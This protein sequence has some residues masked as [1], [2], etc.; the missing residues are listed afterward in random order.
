M[1][2]SKRK[3]RKLNSKLKSSTNFN[4]KIKINNMNL[5]PNNYFLTIA[6][7]LDGVNII[8]YEDCV[9]FKV[10]PNSISNN[11]KI[12]NGRGD[13]VFFNCDYDLIYD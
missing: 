12:I 9:G 10:L 5:M 3:N 13:M 11:K 4:L 2:R 7:D 6:Y 1:P 8:R